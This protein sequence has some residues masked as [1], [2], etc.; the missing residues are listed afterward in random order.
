MGVHM[1]IP[2]VVGSGSVMTIP[3]AP[4]PPSKFP[5]GDIQAD[6]SVEVYLPSGPDAGFLDALR[7]RLE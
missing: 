3:E 7:R 2:G 5:H 6:N 1:K 4:R